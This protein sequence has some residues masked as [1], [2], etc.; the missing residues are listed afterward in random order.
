MP[1]ILKFRSLF[2]NVSEKKFPSFQDNI[3]LQTLAI[4]AV[5]EM[6]TCY[7]IIG[8]CLYKI[9]KRLKVLYLL[10]TVSQ[11]RIQKQISYTLF[12]QAVTPL[13]VSIIPLGYL[14]FV[15]LFGG[16]AF[17][18]MIVLTMGFSWVPFTNALLTMIIVG[19][20]RPSL[21]NLRRVG[22]S[23]LHSN[24]NVLETDPIRNNSDK[25]PSLH[26]RM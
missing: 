20:F 23:S 4:A 14:A 8:F 9:Q 13:C 2:Y 1:R 25:I 3:L 6:A 7:S 21:G 19:E 11:R 26:V 10:L 16:T 15:I 22:T 12:V 24:T 18:S 17:W 5:V